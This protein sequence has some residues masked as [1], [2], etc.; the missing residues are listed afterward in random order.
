MSGAEKTNKYAV[1][2]LDKG[3]DIIEYLANQELP[4]SQTEIALGLDRKP[5]EIYRVLVGLESRGY[6]SRDD[7]SGKY[8]LSLKLYNLSRST[9]PIDKIRQCALPFMEDLAVK[10]GQSCHLSMLYQSKTMVVVQARSQVPISI[11]IAEGAVFPTLSTTSGKILLANSNKAV[12]D[13]ILT[14]DKTYKKM[15]SEE[16]RDLKQE[17]AEIRTS[18]YY[19][20]ENSMAS[21]VCDLAV[22]VGHPEGKVVA[23]LAVSS[24]HNPDSKA[25]DNETIKSLLVEAAGKISNQ[26]GC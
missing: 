16:K 6:L 12:S 10:L 17:L 13:M 5:N 20:S 1:P 26:L 7:L 23:A 2:A 11:N 19:F 15:T 3:L 8:S 18:G 14:R 4:K 22:L 24:L 9:S 21:G 25:I